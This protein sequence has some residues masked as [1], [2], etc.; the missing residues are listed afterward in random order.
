[1]LDC[2][3]DS[4]LSR[5]LYTIGVPLMPIRRRHFQRKKGVFFVIE[6]LRVVCDS[7]GFTIQNYCYATF[8]LTIFFA[9]DSK[10]IE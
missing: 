8:A 9:T 4:D 1:V 7:G 5:S 6:I 10:C 3:A 2:D